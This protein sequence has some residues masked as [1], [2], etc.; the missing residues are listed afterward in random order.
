LCWTGAGGE[1]G[2][3]VAFC[4]WEMGISCA[5]TGVC[6]YVRA[7]VGFMVCVPVGLLGCLQVLAADLAS[8]PQG[9]CCYCCFNTCC[10]YTCCFNTCCCCVLQNERVLFHYNG[11]GVPRPT[12]NGEIWVFNSRWGPGAL[13]GVGGGL[14][15]R[16]G[17]ALILQVSWWAAGDVEWAWTAVLNALPFVSTVVGSCLS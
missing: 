15:V 1:V 5:C 9:C 8:V 16:P 2:L 13:K 10:F 3:P 17:G 11:H 12:V 7:C 14:V 6:T 4:G